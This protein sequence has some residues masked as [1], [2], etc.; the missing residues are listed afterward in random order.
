MIATLTPD[1]AMGQTMFVDEIPPGEVTGAAEDVTKL[2]PAV[3][4]VRL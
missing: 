2:L 1:S 3:R 4:V